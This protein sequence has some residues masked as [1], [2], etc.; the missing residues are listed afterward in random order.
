MIGSSGISLTI[1]VCPLAHLRLPCNR[2]SRS[3][4]G[5]RK[6]QVAAHNA[7][8]ES[9]PRSRT[10]S[11]AQGLLQRYPFLHRPTYFRYTFTPVSP[12]RTP[13]AASATRCSQ[14]KSFVRFAL[15]HT[16]LPKVQPE[17]TIEEETHVDRA[18]WNVIFHSHQDRE[19]ICAR[20]L[21]Q[22]ADTRSR[23]RPQ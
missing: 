16:P 3:N 8:I 15:D 12:S 4:A 7:T 13:L 11:G 1:L 19:R 5:R 10:L 14:R 6:E 18:V 21:R 2:Y 20:W 17:L 9:T 23:T 22:R